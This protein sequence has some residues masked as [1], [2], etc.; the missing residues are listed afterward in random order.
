MAA[1]PQLKRHVLL[2]VSF[3]NVIPSFEN[4]WLTHIK[5]GW[6]GTY[7]N[8]TGLIFRVCLELI[9]LKPAL[10]RN[11]KWSERRDPDNFSCFSKQEWC[12]WEFT[13][14]AI[15]SS[16]YFRLY[17]TLAEELR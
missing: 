5:I 16:V 14:I 15:N 3:Q 8:K 9:S 13:K 6:V 10:I 11:R 12:A 7:A 2:K 4:R 17:V 1:R